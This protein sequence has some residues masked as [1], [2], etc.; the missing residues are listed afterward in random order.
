VS[1][2]DVQLHLV[3]NVDEAYEFMRWLST[4]KR[5]HIGIDTET[6]G[7]SQEKDYVRLVQIGDDR[8]GWAIPFERWGGVV[9]DAIRR[10]EGGWILHN[11][12]FDVG[13]TDKEGPEF[14]LPR[15][16][17]R[18]TRPM[19]H[20]LDSR[21]STALK[22]V[23]SR[24]VDP[25]AGAMQAELDAAVGKSG[26]WTWATV[27]IHFQP[28]W[29]Y[30]ALDPVLT[31]RIHD[32]LWPQIQQDALRAYELENAVLWPIFEME[33]YGTHVDRAYAAQQYDEFMKICDEVRARLKEQH[34]VTPGSN[35]PLIA[36]LQELTGFH[37]TERT[38]SGA[39]ALTKEVLELIDHPL[40]QDVLTYRQHQKM[41]STYLDHFAHDVDADDLL[42][43]SINTL[44]ARTGRMSMSNPNLQ[45]LPRRNENRPEATTIRNCITTRYEDGALLMC[46]FDQIEMRIL[47]HVSQDPGMIA[48]FN[49]TSTD[50]FVALGRN[51][52]NDP[53]MV[54]S[55]KRRQLVKNGGYAKIYGAG[56][57]KFAATARVSIDVAR[58]F[59][60]RFDEMY[61]GGRTL[62]NAVQRTAMERGISEGQPF[63]RSPLTGRR[64]IA[65]GGKEYALTNYMIQGMAAEVFK[66][67]VLELDAAGL[68]RFMV[69]P[70][71]DE[72][73][74]DVPGEHLDE[75]VH[76]L[77]KV[78][79]DDNLLSV[80]V[81]ASVS[82]GKRWGEKLAWPGEDE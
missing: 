27:P 51:I 55:D 80:P 31:C 73:I 67:K 13:M 35:P 60:A 30:G 50:F 57:V 29:A 15:D 61:P 42:H 40:A 79:N 52:F 77:K 59:L 64:Q 5:S 43:P 18:D 65:D 28:Y 1:L 34:N 54:K 2:A 72:I 71:H 78:M 63:V 3:D 7:L 16:K 47:A 48:A 19:V 75:A 25:V 62:A 9:S 10:W 23:A 38:K 41:A 33:R 66:T 37:F 74:L 26:G 44:G 69:A 22:N 17:I 8:T 53:T 32:I 58:S 11:A 6:T 81:S 12:P 82:Y 14:K 21:Q 45:N 24:L 4:V 39:L 70:V 46:D 56:I 20:V 76:V 36:L 68:G 49:D